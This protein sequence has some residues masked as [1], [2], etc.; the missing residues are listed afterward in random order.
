MSKAERPTQLEIMGRILTDADTLTRPNL[1]LLAEG[2]LGMSAERRDKLNEPAVESSKII[3]G[4]KNIE[5]RS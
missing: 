4:S 3:N 2:L 5:P 1:L